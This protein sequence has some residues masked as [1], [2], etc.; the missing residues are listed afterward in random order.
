MNKEYQSKFARLMIVARTI[1]K[2]KSVN[3]E[4][5]ARVCGDVAKGTISRY[6]KFLKDVLRY[7]IVYNPH[8][9]TYE[10]YRKDYKQLEDFF[11]RQ[12]ILLLLMALDSLKSFSGVEI[13][14]L[15][16]KLLELLPG[17]EDVDLEELNQQ[18]DL[19]SC[20]NERG[21]IY[22]IS[23]I[24]EAILAEKQIKFDYLPAYLKQDKMSCE[25]IAYGVAWDNDKC[26]LVG[27]DVNDEKIINYRLDRIAKIEI[28][29]KEGVV[30]ENFNL[31]DYLA[32]SWNMFFGPAERVVLKFSQNLRPAIKDNFAAGHYRF[33]EDNDDYFILES[34][35]RGLK[36]LKIWLLGLGTNVEVL[37]P[38]SFRKEMKETIE[39]MSEK[40]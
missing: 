37:E 6:I 13:A 38:E 31:Q 5:L 2:E 21:N 39:Q 36:G 33:I 19:M 11:T 17:G 27:K 22:Y 10:Y 8:E 20:N 26:Y 34:T 12:E 15:Q 18:L 40:Y 28:T 3:R 32:Q 4:E 30:P 35:V 23:K 1:Q 24:T 7:P 16:S 9:H 25:A 14:N 29:D